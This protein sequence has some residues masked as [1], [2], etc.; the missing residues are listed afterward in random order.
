MSANDRQV[1]GEH[2]LK[3]GQVQP[4][5]LWWLWNLNPYQAFIIKYVVRYRDKHGVRDLEKALH[6]IEKLIE[7]EKAHE[8]T[9]GA[10][11]A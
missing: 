2:Y 4:W 1:E 8:R 3:Y 10:K 7:L 5:D 11:K 6:T 9:P